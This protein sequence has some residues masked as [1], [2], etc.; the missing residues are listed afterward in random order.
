M[1]RPAALAALVI[2]AGLA[3]WGLSRHRT[4]PLPDADPWTTLVVPVSVELTPAALESLRRAPRTDVPAQVELG[5]RMLPNA[6]IHLKGHGRFRPV[7]DQPSF[8]VSWSSPEGPRRLHLEN[9]LE[10]PSRL[11][12]FLGSSLFREA[13]I[14]VPEVRHAQVRVMGRPP[15]LYVL[16]TGYDREYVRTAF[17][18]PDGVVLEPVGGADVDGTFQASGGPAP[19]AAPR[20]QDAVAR[21]ARDAADPDLERR[22]AS[23]EQ[24]LE[25]GRFATLLAGEALLGHWD[26]YGVARNNYRIH[27]DPASGRCVVLSHG[28]D[29]LFPESAYPVRPIV[30]SLLARTFLETRQ[31]RD[32]YEREWSRLAVAW[33]DPD[34]LC[35]RVRDQVGRLEPHLS[36]AQR[37]TLRE[38]SRDLERR[39]TQRCAAVAGAT[40][41]MW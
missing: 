6:Q 17:G 22:W 14:P 27:W 21:L 11:H 29:Q 32:L 25:V 7:D 33:M 1:N 12:A 37:S 20:A 13:G 2:G 35:R 41:H 26:G 28:M 39:I 10:D 18:I 40:T 15:G 36:N 34:A 24:R 23:L 38:E 9:S 19:E 30:S 8:T 3:A 5:G 16:R 31:G 4:S